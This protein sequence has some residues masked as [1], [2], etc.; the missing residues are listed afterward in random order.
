MTLATALR[1]IVMPPYHQIVCIS[2]MLCDEHV[3]ACLV[4]LS[5]PVPAEV[6]P[7]MLNLYEWCCM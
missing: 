6:R 5:A 2:H 3:L 1:H 7:A 4:P